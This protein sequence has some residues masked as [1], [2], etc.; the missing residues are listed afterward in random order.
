MS[1]FATNLIDVMQSLTHVPSGT[2]LAE[3]IRW[4]RSAASRA[5]GL[6]GSSLEVSE[7]LII[8][9]AKQVHS[10]FIG[11]EIDVV[12]CDADWRVVHVVSPMRRRR[13]TRWVAGARYVIELPPGTAARVEID[14]LLELV[15]APVGA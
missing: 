13:I 5:K 6:I 2:V 14:D 3:R 11:G 15:E 8:A 4:A 10:F 7:A 1:S 12:F 9:P